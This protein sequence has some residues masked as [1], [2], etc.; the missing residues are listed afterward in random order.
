MTQ[1][2]RIDR[3]LAA[4]SLLTAALALLLAGLTVAI[5]IGNPTIVAPAINPEVPAGTP[6][7]LPLLFVTI[8]CGAISGFHGLVSSGTTSK[9]INNERDVRFVGYFGAIGEG[10]LALAAILAT[11]AGFATLAEWQAVYHA[12]GEGS[13]NAFVQGGAA[14]VAGGVGLPESIAVTLLTVMAVLFAAV[15]LML[16]YGPAR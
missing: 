5:L 12:F 3:S 15:V 16:A 8:A 7:M 2:R 6:S 4:S 1:G 9:Q 13:V 10:S 11:T 14:I